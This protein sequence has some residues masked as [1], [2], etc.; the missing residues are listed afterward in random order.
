MCRRSIDTLGK[1][2]GNAY[3]AAP[4][5]ILLPDVPL[6]NLEALFEACHTP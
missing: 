5:N 6:E 3:I 4:S 1:R 2:F